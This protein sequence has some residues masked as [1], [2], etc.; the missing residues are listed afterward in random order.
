MPFG[1]CDDPLLSPTPEAAMAAARDTVIPFGKHKGRTLDDV[2]SS[3]SGLLYLDKQR[4]RDWVR[5]THPDMAA[6]LDAYLSEPGVSRELDRA[7][8]L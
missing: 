2:A 7:L 3:T 5:E 6:A 8:G 4:G 1:V